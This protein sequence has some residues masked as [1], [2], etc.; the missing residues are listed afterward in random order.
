MLILGGRERGTVEHGLVLPGEHLDIA[1]RVR[2]GDPVIGWRGDESM[3]VY[4]FNQHRRCEVWAFDRQGIRYCAASV[5]VD[6][7]GWQHTLLRKLRDGD[8]HRGQTVFDEINKRNDARDKARDAAAAARGD[9]RAEKLAWALQ[10]DIG[11]LVSGT[12]RW[13]Y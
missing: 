1:T 4:L 9:E 8:W 11:H 6:V 10:R 3:D 2:H 12:R 7:P 13:H 5:N